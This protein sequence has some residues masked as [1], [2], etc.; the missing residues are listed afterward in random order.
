MN[1]I[2]NNRIN[3]LDVNHSMYWSFRS[4]VTDIWLDLIVSPTHPNTTNVRS[5]FCLVGGELVNLDYQDHDGR[6]CFNQLI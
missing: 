6:I 5:G 2:S 4:D 3:D 1:K